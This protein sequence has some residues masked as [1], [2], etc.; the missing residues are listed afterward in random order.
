MWPEEFKSGIHWAIWS[1]S[2]ASQRVVVSVGSPSSHAAR[3]ATF[4][5]RPFQSTKDARLEV[6]S[7]S[8]FWR[9]QACAKSRLPT[10]S[11]YLST[12]RITS[13]GQ[14]GLIVEATSM[15]HGSHSLPTTEVN[16]GR[17]RWLLR[18][19][20]HTQPFGKAL[21][22]GK[23]LDRDD[24]AKV[25]PLTGSLQRLENSTIAPFTVYPSRIIHLIPATDKSLHGFC[26]L[27]PR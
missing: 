19:Q 2:V 8:N 1:P 17:K 4:S 12:S 5:S 22:Y 27:Y 18:L 14:Q 10:S 3:F 16:G 23:P 11:S 9:K 13:V 7:W 25:I 20:D 26:G 6:P 15:R 21:V 24:G